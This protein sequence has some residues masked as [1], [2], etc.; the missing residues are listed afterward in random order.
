[1]VTLDAS[2]GLFLD[3]TGAGHLFGG[4]AAML[5]T[6]T[7]RIAGHGFAAAG[8]IAGTS[9]A[10]RALARFA[11]GTIVACGGETEKIAPLPIAALDCDDK[12][13]RALR[14]AGLK[15]IGMVAERLRS[16]LSERLGKRFVTRLKVMLGAEEQPLEPRRPLPDLMAE[17]HFAEPV[18]TQTVISASLLSLA[19][20]L[21]SILERQGRGLRILQAAFFRADGKVERITVKT[22]EALRDPQAMLRLLRQ[23]L[24]ALADPLD[25][26]FGFDLIR[27]EALLAEETKP[28]TV[29]FDSDENTRRQIRFLTDRLSA[30]FGEHRVQRF[31]A[32]DTHIPE[33]AS[34]AVPAQDDEFI[35]QD[36]SLKR[37][38]GDPPRR[39]LRLLQ[40]PEEI[41]A[42]LPVA[43]DGPPKYFRWRQ[44]RHDIARA[45]GPERIAM[46]WWR[47]EG[48]TRDYFRVE[49][50]DGQRFWLYRDGLY[51]QNGFA[52]R[53]YLQG[54]F[55]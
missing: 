36:W 37:R 23:K 5:A 7:Q 17:Q 33:A 14:H 49:T 31:V 50:K 46:E 34:V 11:P 22:G 29:S 13:L 54:L 25:P 4:E 53:W 24:D 52:P 10:A 18:V 20:S 32:Q 9:L 15:T 30:R 2:D 28:A 39:P 45:E 43:P 6:V 12:I 47:K 21:G 51:R 26:G 55:A 27:L 16:E 3:I 8:A 1:L 41:E 42:G 48:L 44:C 35:G 19:E 38:P 40:R